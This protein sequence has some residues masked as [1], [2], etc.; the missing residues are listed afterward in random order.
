M[1][2]AGQCRSPD[3][4]ML[5]S[6]RTLSIEQTGVGRLERCSFLLVLR[7]YHFY[8]CDWGC[9][10][11]RVYAYRRCGLRIYREIGLLVCSEGIK[12]SS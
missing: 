5:L 2:C 12:F 9:I 4:G 3:I 7:A 8:D 10:Y 11:I 1:W 6:L